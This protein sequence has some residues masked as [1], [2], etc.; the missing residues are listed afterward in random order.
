MMKT[1][2]LPMGVLLPANGTG[3]IFVLLLWRMGLAALHTHHTRGFKCGV[4]LL[5]GLAV[6]DLKKKLL[7]PYA[8]LF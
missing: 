4:D 8:R 6:K 5:D 1:D 2:P 3:I 7:P